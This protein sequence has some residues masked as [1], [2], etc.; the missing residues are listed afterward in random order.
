[1]TQ[2]EDLMPPTTHLE[3]SQNTR[4]ASTRVVPVILVNSELETLGVHIVSDG[5]YSTWKSCPVRLEVPS[6]AHHKCQ[7]QLSTASP[8]G[9]IKL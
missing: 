8:V 2:R 3:M 5:L 1:M 7:A 9:D 4:V 6:P